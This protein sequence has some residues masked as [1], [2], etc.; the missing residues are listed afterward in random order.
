MKKGKTIS[1]Y[2]NLKKTQY[3]LDFFD[4]FIDRDTPLFIDPWAIRCGD[5]EFSVSCYQKM[6]S[7]F[8]RLIYFINT[9][10]EKE[11]LDLLDNLHEPSETGLGYTENG[12]DGSSIGLKKS[13][14]IYDALRNSKAVKSGLLTDLEDTALHIEGIGSDNI[15]DIVTNIIRYDLIKYTQ[16]QCDSYGIE[17]TKTQTKTFWDE[18]R[19]DFVQKNEERILVIENKKILLVPKKILRRNLSISYYDFY[20][21]GILEFEQA[22]HYDLRTSLCRTLKGKIIAKPYKKTLEKDGRYNLSR[23]LVFDYINKYPILLKEYKDRKSKELSEGSVGAVNNKD[24]LKRQRRSIDLEESVEE[25]ISKL[26]S[27]KPGREYAEI[28]HEHIYDCL[29]MIFNNPGTPNYLSGPKKD[30]RFNEGRKRIDVTFHNSSEKGFFSRLSNYG[31]LFCAKILFECKN[32]TSDLKNPEYDQMVGRF[33]NRTSTI[34]YIVCR[35][36]EDQKKA[37]E[38]SRDFLINGR[39]YIFVLTDSDIIKLLN[40]VA[41]ENKDIIIDELLNKKMAEIV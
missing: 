6:H 25:K 26:R 13:R 33:N 39:G 16:E 32:Y 2:F 21:K 20:R 15:S 38:T 17:L 3:D 27:I 4:S 28:Y 19:K 37:I 11:A 24:I 36:I 34:G 9:G 18:E 29:N 23:D 35:S 31:Y 7:V 22:R 10:N 5:D 8:E 1:Q 40:A 30:D 14:D 41:A 12:R